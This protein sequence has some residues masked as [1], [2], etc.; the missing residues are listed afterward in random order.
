MAKE[1]ARRQWFVPSK[2]WARGALLGV[3]ALGV[4]E[5]GLHVY[6]AKKAPNPGDWAQLVGPVAEERREGDVV[7]VA[8]LWGDP[9]ARQ[10]L[11]DEVFPLKDAA[12][13]DMTRYATA[14]EIG[15]LG[16]TSPELAGFREVS[17]RKVGPFTLRRLE[18]P[19]YK[20]IVFDFVDNLVGGRATVRT[21]DPAANCTYTTSARPVAG[22]LGGHPTFPAAR[23]ECPGGYFL[24]VS[25]TVIADHDFRPRRCIWAHPPQKGEVIIRF[26]DVSLGSVI[27]GHGGMYWMIERDGLGAPVSISVRVDGVEIGKYEHRDGDGWSL[28]EMPLGAHAGKKSAVVEFGVSTRNFMHRHFCFEADSR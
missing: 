17:T 10:A 7:V 27:R 4:A 18:N 6:H 5:L 13:P 1:E 19:N 25:Q 2:G 24:N 26:S 22:G 21:T 11:G 14:L 8:P 3:A 28:F 12:R 9:L 15:M 20:P 23:F 16:Q